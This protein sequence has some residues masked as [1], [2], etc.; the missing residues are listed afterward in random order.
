MEDD[1]KM[2]SPLPAHFAPETRFEVKTG[3]AVP[4]RATL[5]TEL[6][7]LHNRLLRDLLRSSPN[8]ELNLLYRHAAR[9]AMALAAASGLPLLVLP[10]LLR[11]KAA[12]AA[13]Y[14]QRQAGLWMRTRLFTE[15]TA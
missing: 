9:E 12:A 6:E 7:R 2:K 8:A 11:E 5:E 4:F 15:A 13:R 1:M 10:E 3:A 14:S